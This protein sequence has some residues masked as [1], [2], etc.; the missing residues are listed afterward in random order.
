LARAAV[1]AEAGEDLLA[2]VHIS[3]YNKIILQMGRFSE[4]WGNV[5]KGVSYMILLD[6]L[7]WGMIMIGL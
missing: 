6:F 1:A 3:S 7:C 2:G 4:I 5:S